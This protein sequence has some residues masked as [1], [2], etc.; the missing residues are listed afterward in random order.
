[1]VRGTDNNLR[2]FGK[3]ATTIVALTA[4]ATSLVL[5]QG[6]TATM[7][8]VVHDGTGRVIPGVTVTIMHT[9]TGLTRTVQT[10]E[11]GAHKQPSLHEGAYEV[12]AEAQGFKKQVRNEINL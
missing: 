2:A 11:N 5:A 7:S 8:G 6:A 12:T 4:L 9:E 10:S 3:F 1:M